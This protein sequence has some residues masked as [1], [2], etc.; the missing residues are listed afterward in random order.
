VIELKNNEEIRDAWAKGKDCW[1]D[2]TIPRRQYETVVK[3]ELEAY[4]KGAQIPPYNAFIQTLMRLPKEYDNHDASMLDVG[5]S[6]AYYKK[7]M[8][9]AGFNYDYTACDF[10][11]DF[12]VLAEELYP[13]VKFDIEDA[14]KLSYHDGQFDIVVSGCCM[15][16][17]PEYRLVV[18]EAA[19]VARRFVIFHRQPILHTRPTTYYLKEA[20]GIP[21]VEIHFGEMEFKTLLTMAGLRIAHVERVFTNSENGGYS[22]LT[23]L[24]EK[25]NA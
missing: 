7:I 20:Y 10:N 18:F 9:I 24:T 17:I 15:L 13:G 12:K 2:K 16:H 19:R 6:G 5:A 23:Y 4:S 25:V 14:T 21:C 1:R 8:E 22:H 11:P 3:N